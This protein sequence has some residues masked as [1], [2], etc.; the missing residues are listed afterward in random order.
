M[1]FK[2]G[3]HLSLIVAVNSELYGISRHCLLRYLVADNGAAHYLN[4]ACA[5]LTSQGAFHGFFNAALAYNIVEGIAAVPVLL[6]F[7][8]GYG[9]H[10][11]D[12]VG[13]NIAHV[14]NSHRFFRDIHTVKVIGQLLYPD[15][16]RHGDILRKGV[17][18]G[19]GEVTHHHGVAYP[20]DHPFL[21]VGVAFVNAVKGLHG[22]HTFLG[23]AIYLHADVFSQ[24]CHVPLPVSLIFKGSVG[25]YGKNVLPLNVFLAKH[26]CH[27]KDYA[28]HR[29]VVR[30]KERLL[31][32]GI[33]A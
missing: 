24:P 22:F 15:H 5:L 8:G 33:E 14:I 20:C 11:S 28:V 25:G 32:N 13:N 18:V 29:L 7:L 27:R 6:V 9:S 19:N 31:Y 12:K 21:P 1:V 30:G 2:N 10:R 16:R 17:A 26:L 23:S 4:G 3:L